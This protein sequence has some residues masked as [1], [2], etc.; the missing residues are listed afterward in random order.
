MNARA[1]QAVAAACLA[2]LLAP[3]GARAVDLGSRSISSSRQFVVYAE[4]PVLR[5]SAASVADQVKLGLHRL[6]RIRGG[7]EWIAPVVITMRPRGTTETAE[8]PARVRLVETVQGPKIEVDILTGPSPVP[9]D[10]HRRITHAVLLDLALREA[11]RGGPVARTLPRW[12]VLGTSALTRPDPVG[13]KTFAGLVESGNL[14]DL[15]VFILNPPAPDE[16]SLDAE[17]YTAYAASLVSTILG[18]EDGHPRFRRLLGRSL[19]VNPET[20]GFG[21]L[22]EVL[23]A[24]GGPDNL[25][26]LWSLELAALS[27]P[28]G[29]RIAE[30][31]PSLDMVTE[32]LDRPITVP[33]DGPDSTLPLRRMGELP[34]DQ[35]VAD[36]LRVAAREL[37]VSASRANPLV[38][39]ILADLAGLC[40]RAATGERDTLP[41][42]VADLERLAARLEKLTADITDH[43]NWIE[44]TQV[45]PA[46]DPF[47]SYFR[48]AEHMMPG[49]PA[50]ARRPSDPVSEYL[51]GMERILDP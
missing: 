7:S 26:R 39:P 51:D 9:V 49:N 48:M 22:S 25:H 27:H 42:R 37:S 44:A 47:E 10:F 18:I 4:D 36:Q 5:M 12:I 31:G 19:A 34:R 16:V 40:S 1:R 41:P 14:P 32:A 6:L 29:S 50:T 21:A 33:G 43:L 24:V 17:I 30:A 20:D 45:R 46:N 3:S 11:G 8:S 28:D 35:A 38:T 13:R 2:A 23:E 15:D